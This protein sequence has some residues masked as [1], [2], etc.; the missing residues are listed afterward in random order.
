MLRCVRRKS[1][2]T[3]QSRWIVAS[4]PKA[5]K[6]SFIA[7]CLPLPRLAGVQSRSMRTVGGEIAVEARQVDSGF[8]NQCD[9][10]GDKVQ[11]AT[12]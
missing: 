5:P 2:T 1:A 12:P 10:P 8:R 4:L 9:K 11:R 7:A 3:S 6:Q